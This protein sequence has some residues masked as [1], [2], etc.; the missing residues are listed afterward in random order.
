MNLLNGIPKATEVIWEADEQ[1]KGEKALY[2]MGGLGLLVQGIAIGWGIWKDRRAGKRDDKKEKKKQETN[3]LKEEGKRKT[4]Q[5]AEE[6][7]RQT[8]RVQEEKK[9]ETDRR[10]AELRKEVV[11]HRAEIRR[12]EKAGK[13]QQTSLGMD[14]WKQQYRQ[15]VPE[16]DTRQAEEYTLIYPWLTEGYDIGLVAPTNCGKTTLMMQAAMDLAKGGCTYPLAPGCTKIRPVR[17]LYFALEQSKKDIKRRYGD[18][19]N[20][21]PMLTVYDWPPVK[22]ADILEIIKQEMMACRGRGIVVI[23]DNWTKLRKKKRPNRGRLFLERLG[24]DADGKLTD[25]LPTHH[26]QGAPHEKGLRN[27]AGNPAEGLRG[28]WDR[29]GQYAEHTLP[30]QKQPG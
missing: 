11:D 30:P 4:N 28:I 24:R 16:A 9:R 18:I 17:V 27:G 21:L 7:K 26:N 10:K 2:I 22:T 14:E 25:R 13:Q 12:Q 15:A 6:A 29:F 8:I 19:E 5:M 1:G 23:I 20:L 3:Q